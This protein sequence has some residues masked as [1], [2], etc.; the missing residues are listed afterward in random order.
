MP[1]QSLTDEEVEAMKATFLSLA[2]LCQEVVWQRKEIAE[3]SQVIH[4]L[5][6]SPARQATAEAMAQGVGHT[7]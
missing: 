1:K 6:F 5:T 2:S 3:L 4:T 7:P